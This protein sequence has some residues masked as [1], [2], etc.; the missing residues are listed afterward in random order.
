MTKSQALLPNILMENS[1]FQGFG[2][3]FF[4]KLLKP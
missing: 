3:F 4:K 2:D 1:N